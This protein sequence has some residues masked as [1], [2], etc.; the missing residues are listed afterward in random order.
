MF[1]NLGLESKEKGGHFDISSS[2]T[3]VDILVVFKFLQHNLKKK[4][5]KSYFFSFNNIISQWI[6]IFSKITK[7]KDFNN[8]QKPK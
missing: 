8:K 3:F 1:I 6:Y 4:L 2:E 5:K 7:Q